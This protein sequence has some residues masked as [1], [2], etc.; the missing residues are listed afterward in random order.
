MDYK[1]IVKLLLEKKILVNG[2][3]LSSLRSA[4]S[5]ELEVVH[6][7]IL[8]GKFDPKNPLP[9]NDHEGTVEIVQ[10]HTEVV[11]KKKEV[12]DF[13]MYLKQRHKAIARILQNRPELNRVTS[14]SRIKEKK[15]QEKIAIIGLVSEKME[16]K[17]GHW[18]LTVEDPSA[19]IR[20]IISKNNKVPF[21]AAKDLVLDEV[22]GISGTNGDDVIFADNIYWPDVPLHKEL[23]KS[24]NEAYAAFISDLHVGSQE[25]LEEKFKRFIDWTNGK[26]GGEEQKAV[27]EK[28]RY[29]FVTGDLVAGVGVYPGQ[30]NEVTI[31]SIYDQYIKVAEYLKQIPQRIKIIICPGN[32]DAGRISE[33]QPPLSMKYAPDLNNMP[34]VTMISNPGM[35]NIHKQPGFPGIDV[36]CYHGYSFNYYINN[37]DSIRNNGGYHRA[38][39]VMEFLLK[40]RHLCPTHTST[41][42]VPNPI[43]DPLVISQV[44]DIMASG[45]IHYT[46]VANYNNVT[47]ICASCWEGAT[48]FQLKLGH[49]PEPARVPIVNLQNRK[50]KI[51]HF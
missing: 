39:L 40:R 10:N 18:L 36:L 16:S 32:H 35:V 50:V 17:N 12:N 47:V 28:L 44:P 51:L 8:K 33:P 45:D 30:E 31:S 43:K 14:I 24:P 19:S 37:V 1:E 15:E 26:V 2:Q 9:V 29:L 20:V 23:K 11:M 27:V 21:E 25:F 13:V 5:D 3:L 42:Y 7:T 22:I 46:S 38:D 6:E 34:N 48:A 4:T 49:D 41:T